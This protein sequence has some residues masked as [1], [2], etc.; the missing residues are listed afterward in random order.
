MWLYVYDDTMY[1]DTEAYIHSQSVSYEQVEDVINSLSGPVN[2][3]ID[4]RVD[5]TQVDL[6]GVVKIIWELHRRTKDQNLLKKIY[7]LHA[8]SYIRS[9]WYTIQ[10]FLPCFV[11]RTVIFTHEP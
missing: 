9:L 5:I 6:V 2:A 3:Y 11:R 7:F 10:C 1:V 4:T 8:N